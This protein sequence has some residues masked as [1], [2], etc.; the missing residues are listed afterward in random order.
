MKER[1]II[2][3]ADDFGMSPIFN[4]VIDELVVDGIISSVSVMV[5]R[6]EG[7]SKKN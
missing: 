1:G 5:K 3:T 4:K 2:I 7:K 6:E